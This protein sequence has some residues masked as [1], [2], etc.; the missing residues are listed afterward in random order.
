M[1]V[2]CCD[3]LIVILFRNVLKG[4]GGLF[5]NPQA[6]YV[7]SIDV[8]Q[9]IANCIRIVLFSKTSLS[10]ARA[11]APK[12]SLVRDHGKSNG[13]L[14]NPTSSLLLRLTRKTPSKFGTNSVPPFITGKILLHSRCQK[15]YLNGHEPFVGSR[16]SARRILCFSIP[17][18][19]SPKTASS[20]PDVRL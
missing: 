2:F 18:T 5:R 1:I 19:R 9:K 11:C 6:L 8:P 12:W 16:S 13:E 17:R 14:M 3:G 4:M 7:D 10:H 15:L 20:G